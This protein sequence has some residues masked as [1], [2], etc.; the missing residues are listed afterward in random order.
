VSRSPQGRSLELFFIDGKPDGMQTAEEINWTG[1]VLLAPRTRIVDALKRRQ[2]QHTGV[3]LLLGDDEHGE[4]LLY[5]GES[6]NMA[7]RLRNHDTKK[8]WWTSAVL[9]TTGANSLHKAHVRYLEARLVE[10]ARS[11]GRIGLDNGNQPGGASL[12]EAAENSM[13]V[14]LDTLMMVLPAMR[15]DCFLEQTRPTIELA[16]DQAETAVFE[17]VNKKN[18]IHATAVIQDGEV[19]VQAGSQAREEWRGQGTAKNSSYAELHR[20][21]VRAGVLKVEGT[22]TVFARNYAFKSPSAAASVVTGRVTNG[23]FEWKQRGTG[24]TYKE[25]ETER[26]REGQANE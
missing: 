17:L 7:D 20:E 5:V 11:V 22:Q 23:T 24:K 12:P 18:R 4:P 14:F 6:E 26:L 9:I 15:I 3:Y 19:V 1:H 21:L 10:I 25:W 13:E 16:Q 2:A 8:D